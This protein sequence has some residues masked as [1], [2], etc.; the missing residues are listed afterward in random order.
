[1]TLPHGLN[2]DHHYV[3][4]FSGGKDSVATWLY[5]SRELKLPHVTCTFADTSH[6]A[7]VTRLYLNQLRDSHGLPL[8]CVVPRLADFRG[9]L[10]PEK[11]SARLGI[12]EPIDV[13]DDSDPFWQ[14]PLTMESLAI[15]KRRFAS[16]MVRFCT[17][18]LKLFP[19]RRWMRERFGSDQPEGVVR[20]AGVRSDES[21]ARAARP[22]FMPFDDFMG[23]PL[24][25]PIKDWSAD[26]VF[27][28]HRKHGVPPNPLYKLGMGRVGCFPCLFATKS[29]LCQLAT[30][31]PEAFAATGDMESR[32][33]DAVGKTAMSFFSNDKTPPQ[34]RSQLDAQSGKR[35]PIA[36]DVQRWALGDAPSDNDL[37]GEFTEDWTEDAH[38][39]TS[40]YGLCE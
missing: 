3:I 35:F 19:Q 1:M 31:I 38:M 39:C 14:H 7:A 9:E 37:F 26:D 21:P 11:I 10:K 29:E 6:E 2:P 16:S 24:W 40:Q 34:Y 23:V 36:E 5:L 28:L 4:G 25:L 20:V 27:A 15:L 33:A 8:E 22:D 17:T 12:P 30:R 13:D 18:H 32:V